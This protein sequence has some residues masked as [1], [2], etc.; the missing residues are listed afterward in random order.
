M[1]FLPVIHLIMREKKMLN[2]RHVQFVLLDLQPVGHKPCKTVPGGQ[3][4]HFPLAVFHENYKILK[5]FCQIS[6]KICSLLN[7]RVLDQNLM[8]KRD[9]FEWKLCY[10]DVLVRLRISKNCKK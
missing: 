1:I 5:M 9:E 8:I 4:R 3:K 7:F 10:F 6:L 2:F